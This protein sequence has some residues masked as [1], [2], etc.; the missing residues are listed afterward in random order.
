MPAAS[1]L[2]AEPREAFKRPQRALYPLA[3]VKRQVEN[4]DES[5]EVF[6][7]RAGNLDPR[8]D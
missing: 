4:S 3:S 8:H 6:D 5:V 7:S 2:G 1:Q